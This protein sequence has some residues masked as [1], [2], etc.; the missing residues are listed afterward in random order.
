MSIESAWSQP[1]EEP[2]EHSADMLMARGRIDPDFED[3]H[4]AVELALQGVGARVRRELPYADIPVVSLV[5]P[6][7]R[8]ESIQRFVDRPA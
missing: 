4:I 3:V 2:G 7:E 8:S 6:N 5:I 1:R